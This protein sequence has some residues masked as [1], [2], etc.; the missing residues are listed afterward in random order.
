MM[1][2]LKQFNLAMRYIDMHLADEIDFR[3]VAQIAGCS[4]YH[5]RRVFAHLAGIS[6]SEYVRTRRLSQ[7]AVELQ[8]SQA[9]VIDVAVKYGYGSADSFTR[10]FSAMH[11][12]TPSEAKLAGA[13]L[14]HV[15]PIHFQLTVYGGE[16]MDYRIVEKGAFYIVGLKRQIPLQHEGVNPA[17]EAMWDSL[18]DHEY[19]ALESLS[20]VQPMGMLNASINFTEGRAEGSLLD[21]YVGVATTQS[22]SDKWQ[23]L[24]VTA[25]TW[26]VF[27][28]RGEFPGALQ[29]T[30]RRIYSEWLLPSEYEIN[31]GPEIL[32]MDGD[33]ASEADDNHCEIWIPVVKK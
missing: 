12:I 4:E 21:N 9:R 30:W 11:N 10:A 16:A 29:N 15:S 14:K 8:Q 18:T 33:D 19:E 2:T 31:R 7:A 5:F 1:D 25:S 26:A 27:T 23:V 6:L 32:W 24:S 17:I 28:S 3:Q 13:S 22:H 20:D